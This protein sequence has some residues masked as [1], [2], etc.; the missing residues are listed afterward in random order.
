[1]S[2]KTG[3]F[4]VVVEN[5]SVQ[6][7]RGWLFIPVQDAPSIQ[8]LEQIQ[9]SRRQGRDRIDPQLSGEA[10]GPRLL[11]AAGI[12]SSSRSSHHYLVATV[13]MARWKYA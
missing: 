7:R 10:L 12:A 1:M 3:C 5:E 13:W 8:N 4:G 2:D 6:K 11:D 9:V